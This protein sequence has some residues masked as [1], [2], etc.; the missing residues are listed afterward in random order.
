MGIAEEEDAGEQEEE[1]IGKPEEDDDD[2]GE[3]YL[4][5]PLPALSSVLLLNPTYQYLFMFSSVRFSIRC[6]ITPQ[7]VIE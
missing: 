3:S 1:L 2:A 6:A 4:S 5:V 7:L